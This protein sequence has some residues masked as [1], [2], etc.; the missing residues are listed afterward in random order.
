MYTPTLK[1]QRLAA[2]FG[3]GTDIL[4]GWLNDS[5]YTQAQVAYMVGTSPQYFAD[6]LAAPEPMPVVVTTQHVEG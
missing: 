3:F 5:R 2:Q 1:M 4:V 6:L